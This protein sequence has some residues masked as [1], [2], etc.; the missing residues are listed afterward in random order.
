[1]AAVDQRNKDEELFILFAKIV[2][3]Q[4]DVELQ[5]GQLYLGRSDFFLLFNLLEE[6]V[7][8]NT[9]DLGLGDPRG[10][11]NKQQIHIFQ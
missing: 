1:M 2:R 5:P 9:N 4:D 3:S 6:V 7:D 8:F 10:F 11:L